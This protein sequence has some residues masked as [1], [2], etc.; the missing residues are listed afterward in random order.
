QQGDRVDAVQPRLGATSGLR[1]EKHVVRH[2]GGLRG[3]KH[4]VRHAGGLRGEKYVVRH[5][6][7]LR[8]LAVE[9]HGRRVLTISSSS[10]GLTSTS[11]AFEPSDGPTMPRLSIRS[12]SRP[13]LANPTRSLRCSIEVDPNCDVTTSSI[14]WTRRSRSSPMSSSVFFLVSAAGVSTSGRNSGSRWF[15]QNFTTSAISAS[16]TQAPWT[17]IGFD[18][19]IG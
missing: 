10:S 3:E 18:A 13:A 8:T 1:G 5:P 4:V 6:Y 16:D 12:I 14:A 2:A 11:R 9:A 19:P 7:S 17:R 15:L